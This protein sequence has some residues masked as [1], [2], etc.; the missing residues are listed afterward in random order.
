[1]NLG[2]LL[3]FFIFFALSF[4]ASFTWAENFSGSIER[5]ERGIFLI[6]DSPTK[7]GR[8][9]LQSSSTRTLI[10]IG[11]LNSGDFLAAS[12]TLDSEQNI[13]FVNSIDYVGL[14]KLLGRWRSSNGQLFEFASFQDLYIYKSRPVATSVFRYSAAPSS[15]DSWTLLLS[16]SHKKRTLIANVTFGRAN[17]SLKLI[18][19]ETGAIAETL[20][21][22]R[23]G[24]H[25]AVSSQPEKP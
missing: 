23:Q 13:A 24:G 2:F 5:T 8:L 18:D 10:Q 17:A 6:L 22:V 4:S 7:M 3:R 21:L 20:R 14:K 1:M 12:G 9:V 16:D 11:R 25:D 15:G 19:S